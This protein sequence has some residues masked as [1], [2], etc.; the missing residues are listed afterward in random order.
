MT[1]SL[2]FAL[3]LVAL[4][5]PVGL[6]AQ[7]AWTVKPEWVRAHESFLASD[8]LAGRGSATRDEQLAAT[9]IAS[10]FEGYGLLPPPGMKGYIQSASV[11]SVELDGHAT[12]AAGNL[13]FKEGSDFDVL[14][15]TGISSSGI[16]V[17]LAAS[18]VQS[19]KLPAKA[20]VLVS[21]ITDPASLFDIVPRLFKMGATLVLALQTPELSSLY[22]MI[23]GKTEPIV[24]LRDDPTPPTAPNI[25][26]LRPEAAAKL[27]SNEAS[28]ALTIHPLPVVPRETFNAIGYLPGADSSAGTLL[29]SAHLDH[30]GVGLPVDGDSIYNGANDDASGTTAVLELAHAFSSRPRLRRSVLFACFGSEELGE[31]GSI[32]FARNSPVPLS[33]LVAD[34]EFEVI[35]LQDPR[36]PVGVL[37]LTGWERSNLGT[38]LKEHGAPLGPD[39][40]PEL[41]LF[42]RSDNYPL[43]LQG[44]V[45]HTVGGEP[46]P[47][48]LHQPNDD[49]E[50]LDWAFMTRAIQSLIEPVRWLADS[51]FRPQWNPGGQPK[52][53]NDH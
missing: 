30:L 41:N 4:A 11:V 33:S 28:L 12:L 39:A 36:M 25:L 6:V 17:R 22:S 27:P 15:S 45:A 16:L 5:A 48:T 19:A 34:I 14:H 10:Q 42:Q 26:L 21:G 2:R 18:D 35:G 23:G 1:V 32:Y 43:A 9:Y 31:L 3:A 24:R 46:M 8:A 52:A 51:D 47:S 49:L 7:Q 50:H 44:V 20:A 38:V 13:T 40:Y 53:A 29:L 37:A